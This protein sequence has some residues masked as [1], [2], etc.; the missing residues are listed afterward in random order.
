MRRTENWTDGETKGRE[1][2]RLDDVSSRQRW[3]W[4]TC[5]FEPSINS[6]EGRDKTGSLTIHSSHAQDM[7]TICGGGA[8]N[9]WN[10]QSIAICNSVTEQSLLFFEIPSKLITLMLFVFERRT[11]LNC[12]LPLFSIFDLSLICSSSNQACTHNL[13]HK[14]SSICDACSLGNIFLPH[15]SEVVVVGSFFSSLPSGFFCKLQSLANKNISV[16]QVKN[17]TSIISL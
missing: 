17:L 12:R 4:Q 6:F 7:N 5:F 15:S 3:F 8:A 9:S 16:C 13:F 14:F 2:I 11:V 10:V 1:I